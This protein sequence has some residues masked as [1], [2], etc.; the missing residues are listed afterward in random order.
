MATKFIIGAQYLT[1][2]ETIQIRD[3]SKGPEAWEM[4]NDDKLMFSW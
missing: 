4:E 2:K 1:R 3:N